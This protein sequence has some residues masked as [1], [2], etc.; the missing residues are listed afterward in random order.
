[1]TP[2]KLFIT[3]LIGGMLATGLLTANPASAAY[4]M[5][6]IWLKNGAAEVGRTYTAEA[7]GY[8]WPNDINLRYQ[9]YRGNQNK[10]DNSYVPIDG[11]TSQRYHLTDVDHLHTVKALVTAYRNGN[12]I[13]QRYSYPSNWIMYD[14]T[15]PKLSG[16][17]EVGHTITGT[18]GPWAT[19]WD[20]SVWWRRGADKIPGADTL[21]YKPTARDAGRSISLVGLGE[22]QFP[23][24]V[25]PIDRDVTH[26][27]VRWGTETFLSGRSVRHRQLRLT[28]LARPEMAKQLGARGKVTIWS[29]KRVVKRGFLGHRK[30][31]T[32]KNM[33]PGPHKITMQFFRTQYYTG[34]KISRTF[35]VH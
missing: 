32:L 19:E 13:G 24:G 20:V 26:I 29:G 17:G 35:I 9:W 18:L 11:A 23:N 12:A 10:D 30:T 16:I 3:A 34:D 21:T 1:M 14:V 22:Y 15:P 31:W 28:G 25:H 27:A 6:V 4:D 2:R 33:K 5:P 7:T 8:N